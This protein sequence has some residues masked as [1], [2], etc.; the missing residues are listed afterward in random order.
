M[1]A[2]SVRLRAA[3]RQGGA[4]GR[5]SGKNRAAPVSTTPTQV[6]RVCV[7]GGGGDSA[8]LGCALA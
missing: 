5:R 6:C 8:V 4:L 3:A 2:N 1:Q 7:C